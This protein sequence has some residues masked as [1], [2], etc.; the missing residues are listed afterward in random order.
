M[1]RNHIQKHK[2][3]QLHSYAITDVVVFVTFVAVLIV[4]V[5]VVV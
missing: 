5:A 1:N 4:V 3:E 2:L